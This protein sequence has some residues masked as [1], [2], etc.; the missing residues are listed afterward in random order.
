MTTPKPRK[1]TKAQE[2]ALDDA[3]V[4]QVATFTMPL[5][6][7]AVAALV[8]RKIAPTPD[9]VAREMDALTKA[10][11]RSII[12][13][14][15]TPSA[16]R[17]LEVARGLLREQMFPDYRGIFSCPSPSAKTRKRRGAPSP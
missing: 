1:L 14:M 15:R 12:K 13:L 2:R 10:Q 9:R 7:A 3:V 4:G 8:A 17:R 6:G 5:A 16:R 11:A